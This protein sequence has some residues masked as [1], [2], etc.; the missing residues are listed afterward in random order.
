MIRRVSAG[1]MPHPGV[2][3][4]AGLN[5]MVEWVRKAID[6][7]DSR[8]PVDPG[9]VTARSRSQFRREK[10]VVRRMLSSDRKVMGDRANSLSGSN[11]L[12]LNLKLT[13]IFRR[14]YAV[15]VLFVGPIPTL[16]ACKCVQT[17]QSEAIREAHAVFRGKVVSIQ[18]LNA[19]PQ[20]DPN[21]GRT[22]FLPPQTDDRQIVTFL[23]ELE[24]K[25]S[26]ARQVKVLV[27]ARPRMCDGYQFKE[28]VRYVVYAT[29]KTR[30]DWDDALERMNSRLDL[31]V[32]PPTSMATVEIPDCPLRIRSDL[33]AESKLLGRGRSLK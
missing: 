16:V 20:R 24:W 15:L 30:T 12:F 5:A 17:S 28:G 27:T 13:T 21:T 19:I 3:K 10:P 29:E 25:G 23:V 4:P 31:K 32:S 14:M 8:T 18:H 2:P 11:P 1:E 33:D 22:T 7:E 9:R 26:I 6:E